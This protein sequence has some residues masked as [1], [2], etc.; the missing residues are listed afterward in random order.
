[1]IGMLNKDIVAKVQ[2]NFRCECISLLEWAC[3]T[4]KSSKVV[5]A[6]WGEENI[7]ANL[8][9]LI[10]DS[11]RAVE[12]GVFVE[13]EHP[14]P[15][16]QVLDNQARANSSNKIDFLF[17][18]DWGARRVRFYVE[19]KNLIE[20]DVIKSSNQTHTRATQLQRRYIRTGI[21]HFLSG[22][23]PEGCL[24]GYV[25]NGSTARVVDGING[26]LIKDGREH[27]CLVHV[28]GHDSWRHYKSEHSSVTAPLEHFYFQFG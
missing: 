19:A 28:S 18:C 1:M 3:L 4:L 20:Y 13:N 11:S 16:Q 10:S 17:Q 8:C 6:N 12:A 27:E 26:L 21:D 15:T 25:L 2:Y 5:D 24:L 7:S 23:Y 14:L 9:A 22:H